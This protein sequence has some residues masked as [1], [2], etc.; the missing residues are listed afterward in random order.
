MLRFYIQT[1]K[2]TKRIL[3]NSWEC[4]MPTNNYIYVR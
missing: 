3:T 2:A 4:G 1:V